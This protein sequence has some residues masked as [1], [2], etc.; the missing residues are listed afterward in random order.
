MEQVW[1]QKIPKTVNI[2][3]ILIRSV[4]P[5]FLE[6]K[7]HKVVLYFVTNKLNINFANQGNPSI[8]FAIHKNQLQRQKNNLSWWK[9]SRKNS[10][11]W[12]RMGRKDGEMSRRLLED[13]RRLL[14]N[15]GGGVGVGR[16]EE[17]R[18]G[19]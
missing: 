17:E 3:R 11:M 6:L 19:D 7:A 4:I 2:S 13:S 1:L 15:G 9:M 8:I 18:H 5:S 14:S 10:S 16:R 12:H